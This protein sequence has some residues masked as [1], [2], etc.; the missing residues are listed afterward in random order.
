MDW[1]V[2]SSGE[3]TLLIVNPVDN[4]VSG[5][6]SMVSSS[7]QAVSYISFITATSSSLIES[8]QLIGQTTLLS[9]TFPIAA[10]AAILLLLVTVSI[11]GTYLAMKRRL[12]APESPRETLAENSCVKCGEKLPLGSNFC[13]N[14]GAKQR[15]SP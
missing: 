10:L 14:C 2:P 5:T 3:Y 8:T 6:F 7:A 15:P 12:R 4:S 9:S 13:D 11:A 1:V